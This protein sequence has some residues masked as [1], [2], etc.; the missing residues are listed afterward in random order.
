MSRWKK[1]RVY[2][3]D[4]SGRRCVVAE[5]SVPDHFTKAAALTYVR[6]LWRTD[7]VRGIAYRPYAVIADGD[8]DV[9]EGPIH[10]QQC[11]YCGRF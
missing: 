7:S 4:L 10:N 8:L 11:P 2:G 9:H 1:A 6:G 5:V 3:T